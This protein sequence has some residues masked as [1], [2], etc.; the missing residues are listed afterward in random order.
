M[1]PVSANFH[2]LAIQDAPKTRVRIYFIGDGVDCTDDNAVQTNGTLL[3]GAVGDTDSNGRIGQNGITFTEM[4]N[5]DKNIQIGT[6]VSYQIGMTLLN[7]DG[8]LNGFSYGRCKVYLDVYDAA[9][10]AWRVCPMGVFVIDIPTKR[11]VQLVSATGY[12]QMQL[13]DTVCDTWWSGLNWSGGLTL[14]QILNSMAAQRGV[15]VSANT[16]AALVN[17]SVTYTEPPFSCVEVTYREVLEYI[18]EATGTIARFDRDGYLDLRFF[19]AAKISG[20]TVTINADTVGNTCL[21]IDIAEYQAAAVDL[22]KVKI[23]EDDIG[24]TV[25]SGT[26]QYTI[27]NNLFLYGSTATIITNRATPIYNRLNGLGAYTPIQ[28]KLIYDWSLEAGDIINI[29]RDSTT[30]PVLIFQQT[31]AWRGGYVT[32]DILADGDNVRPVMDYDERASYRMSSEMSKKVGDN[33]IISKINQTAE[34]IQIQASRVDLT[35]YVTFTNLSTSGQ[36][37]INGGNITTGTIDASTVTVSNINASDISSGTLSADRIAAGSLAIGKLDSAAQNTINGANLQE[38]LIY[39]SKAAGTTSLSGTTTWVTNTTGNQDTWTLKR[40]TYNSSY[41]VLFIATQRKDVGG[42]V[43]CTT[44]QIDNTTTVI[45]GGHITT[46]TIDA[47]VVSV[48]N[49]NASNISSGTLS[50]ARIGAGSI[51]ANKLNSADINASKILT[52]GSMTDAAAATVLNSNIAIGGRNLCTGTAVSNEFTKTPNGDWFVP[53]GAWPISTYGGAAFADT[54]NTQWTASFDYSITGVDVA[55]TLR[56]SPKTSASSYSGGINVAS[57]PVGSSS[58]HAEGTGTITDGARAFAGTSGVLFTGMADTNTN[59]VLTVSNLKVEI[60]NKATSWTQ[61]P[62]DVAADIATAQTTADSANSQEQLIYISKVSGTTTQSATTTWVTNATGNQNTWTIKR[63]TYNS[64]YPV[65]FVATQRKSVGGTVTC[66]T[67]QID[68]TTTVIDGGHIT[69]GTIDASVVSVTNLNASN[70]TSGTMSA[71]KISGGTLTLGGSNN[72]NGTMTVKDANGNTAATVTNAGIVVNGT[73]TKTTL[74]GGAI[75]IEPPSDATKAVTMEYVSNGLSQSM[76][77]PSGG[78]QENGFWWKWGAYNAA[79]L[80]IPG[81]DRMAAQQF[82]Q[83]RGL[84]ANSANGEFLVDS[85]AASAVRTPKIQTPTSDQVLTITGFPD[86]TNR[87]VIKNLNTVGWKRVLTVGNGYGGFGYSGVIDLTITR[88]YN[89]TNNESHKVSLFI[90]YNASCQFLGEQSFSN[91]QIIDKIRY[92][93]DGSSNG[94]LDI[95]YNST[96]LNSVTVDYVVHND[97]GRQQYTTAEGLTIVNDAPSGETVKKTYN[98]AA[99]TEAVGTV[100]GASGFTPAETDVKRSGRVVYVHFYVQNVSIAANTFTL[101]GTLSGVPLPEKNI[102]WLAGGGGHAYDAVTPVYAILETNGNITVRPPS[103]I[104]AV[105]ITIS[106]I[107]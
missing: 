74:N 58:G 41:P 82:A 49:L 27:V 86:V 22:L 88:S 72:T 39:R 13:L 20:S 11:R 17:S 70:I 12:D 50:A 33:E 44:P 106:Y 43:T 38:Q 96:A 42:T 6:A 85:L 51:T 57:I 63:P 31:L 14:L 71:S 93:M 81:G 77:L 19:S 64:S 5:P 54:A 100:T 59:A 3:V 91:T 23:A 9:N 60:G 65:L 107:V 75:I 30:Y 99:D 105:N 21:D 8:A 89:N 35:G 87:R 29:V 101:I 103:A 45:D 83:D 34:S 52:V 92:T 95:H 32:A 25:G 46:G 79:C 97:P 68:N 67:P 55:F 15:F 69:T 73:N 28:A 104:S 90:N 56:I 76:Y 84:G 40:P 2:T 61:A 26:N 16:A 10:S 24:V 102:R 1:Y 78:R 18:A 98:F 66:T 7:T 36:T 62:E 48:T 94:H 80:S 37:T 4:F 53:I 47:S